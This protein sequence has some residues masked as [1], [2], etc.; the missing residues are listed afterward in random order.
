M[1]EE[2]EMASHVETEDRHP[3]GRE[4]A[5]GPQN[6]AIAAKYHGQIWGATLIGEQARERIG[7]LAAHRHGDASTLGAQVI[8]GTPS[9]AQGRLAFGTMN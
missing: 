8:G 7:V 5:G 6:R 3:K 1:G 9:L 4:M 2:A